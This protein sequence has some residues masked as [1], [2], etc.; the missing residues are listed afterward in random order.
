MY[1]PDMLP[2]GCR[3]PSLDGVGWVK[4]SETQQRWALLGSA[5]AP[6]NLQIAAN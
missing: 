1:K 5:R 6:L 4:R 2:L 3:T